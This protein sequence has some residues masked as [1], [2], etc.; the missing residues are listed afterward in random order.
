MGLPPAFTPQ[1]MCSFFEHYLQSGRARTSLPG[2]LSA[3]RD[4]ATEVAMPYPAVGSAALK[5]I[6]K[7]LRGAAVRYPHV[8]RR[9]V[10][11]TLALLIPIAAA[12]GIRNLA[13]LESVACPTLVFYARLAI[14]HQAC[15]RPVEHDSVIVLADVSLRRTHA[16]LRVGVLPSARKIKRRPPRVAVLAYGHGPH[17]HLA[18]GTVLRV[19]LRRVHG[20]SAPTAPLWPLY[21]FGIPQRRHAPWARDLRRLRAIIAAVLPSVDVTRVDGRSLR[22]G[23]ATDLLSAGATKSWVQAQGGWRSDAVL[24]YDRPAPSLRGA[25]LAHGFLRAGLRFLPAGTAAPA[26]VAVRLVAPATGATG[27]RGHLHLRGGG[28]RRHHR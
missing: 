5:Q 1:A 19:L 16:R 18:A 3:W 9:S 15:L 27:R 20:L 2:Y 4:H 13:D 6:R 12:L 22:S 26:A 10:P 21:A 17:A 11:L 7:Y 24:I 14:A 8:V 25:V 23:G 28:W